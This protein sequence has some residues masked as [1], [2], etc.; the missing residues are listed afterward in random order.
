MAEQY[1]G[2]IK[3]SVTLDAATVKKSAEELRGTISKI[4]SAVDNIPLNENLEKMK[5]SLEDSLITS[6]MLTEQLNEAGQA[7]TN[8]GAQA[9]Q[10]AA[11]ATQQV[12]EQ[13]AESNNEMRERITQAAGALRDYGDEELEV[14]RNAQLMRERIE[15]AL[16]TAWNKT[17]ALITRFRQLASQIA[18]TGAAW[19]KSGLSK[20]GSVFFGGARG[21]ES[22]DQ[23]LKKGIRTVLAYGLGIQTLTSL[24]G[25][26]RSAATDALKRMAQQIPEV[27]RDI[28]SLM[29]SLQNLKNS[30]GTM[31]QP[32]LAAVTP[33]LTKLMS[34]LTSVTTKIGE[35]FAA[36]TG[37]KYIYKATAANIDYAKSLD[38]TT[39]AK[40]KKNKEDDK[41]LGAYDKLLVIQKKQKDENDDD[42]GGSSI[43]PNQGLFKKVPIDPKW[44]KI[45]DWLKDMWKRAD[46]F[47]LGAK[48]AEKLKEMLRAIP[49]NYIKYLAGKIGKSLATFFNGI[50]ADMELAREIGNA[51]AQ[52]FNTALTFAYNFVKHFEWK[53]FG[54]WLGEFISSSLRNIDW[55]MLREFAKDFGRGLANAFNG[56]VSTD[57]LYQIGNAIAQLIR[58]AID[59]AFN[60]ITGI[61]FEKLGEKIILGIKRF[62][63]VMN[64][65][66]ETG[67][68]GWQK[69]GKTISDALYGILHTVNK[70]LGDEGL[71]ES[72]GKA[73][74]EFLNQID[75]VAI[76]T[77]V[78]QLIKNLGS[79]F[80]QI[81][82]SALES[83]TLREGLK[84]FGPKIALII[85]GI[86]TANLLLAAGQQMAIGFLRG[87]GQ[88]LLESG[89]LEPLLINVA[90]FASWLIA[91]VSAALIG[92]EAGKHIG[93]ALFPDEAD[94]YDEYKGVEGTIRMLVDFVDAMA[95]EMA[96][97]W[98]LFKERTVEHFENLKR[99]VIEIWQGIK[100][101]VTS[102]GQNIASFFTGIWNTIVTGAQTAFG[103]LVSG[104]ADKFR[105]VYN[106]IMKVIQGIVK[107]L[108]TLASKFSLVQGAASSIRGVA[109]KLHIPGLAQG[110]VIPPNNQ[111]LAMLGDQKHGTNIETPLDTM[112]QAFKNAITEMG[113]TGGGNNQPIL[114]QLDGRTVAQVVWDE[115]KKRY[116]QTG[117][118]RPRM[119]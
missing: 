93:K 9:T 17:K 4:L 14:I 35:F 94:V 77:E 85:G 92:A 25:K 70:V 5:Q 45:A 91:A 117:Q 23:K 41:E 99:R 32:L 40:K 78:E 22:F 12:V 111:F 68:N 20:I 47:E 119:A 36:L 69:L 26:L 48:L 53:Q 6:Q 88:G 46:F 2:D 59:F 51:I 27:N 67:L 116:S 72:L 113:G 95:Y 75:F 50:F 97:A 10:Q 65:V 38:K 104:I 109:H 86:F 114:L 118:Y 31:F 29:S 61:D 13:V 30:I 7:M 102:I 33:I 115:Q 105:A 63:K 42:G 54:R 19:I 101:G 71:R 83:D 107:A 90:Q 21:A 56:L 57:V 81:I 34:M 66:D 74:T 60:L 89:A 43:D 24:F 52:V 18:R 84:Q 28:S 39:K 73:I 15:N 62:F 64:E 58:A 11:Q 100:T 49:W 106:F 8:G 98:G 3:L 55:H 44:L 87:F 37:Q 96:E 112:V 80:L 103:K 110:A 108:N 76:L 16:S 1:D 79:L 82:K